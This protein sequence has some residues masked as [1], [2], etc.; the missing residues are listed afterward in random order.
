MKYLYLIFILFI[1]GCGGDGDSS[2]G[3]SIFTGEYD[4][5]TYCADVDYYNP[6]TG[7]SRKYTLNVEVEN[8][9]VTKIIWG[10]G[11]WL[12]ESHFSPEELDSHGYCSFTSDKGYEYEIQINGNECSSTDESKA[13]SDSDDEKEKTTCPKCDGEKDEFDTYCDDC[14]RKIEE[15]KDREEHT[16]NYCGG[17]DPLMFSTD[18]KC[19]DCKRK[20]EEEE[21]RRE[22]EDENNSTW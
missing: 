3:R 19:S 13:S 15:E 9:E 7:T 14:N 12:D 20:E 22:Q 18:D 1:C 16:C 10:N 11:G 2:T 5:G 17:Y 6:K 8:N 21:R 4:D